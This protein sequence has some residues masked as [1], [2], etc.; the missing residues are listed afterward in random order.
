MNSNQICSNTSTTVT[1]RE[2]SQYFTYKYNDFRE[3]QCLMDVGAKI[4][5][6]SA[7]F[8]GL[9]D[10]NEEGII[11]DFLKDDHRIQIRTTVKKSVPEKELSN[12][13]DMIKE[14]NN[15]FKS[16]LKIKRTDSSPSPMNDSKGNKNKMN[17]NKISENSL[18]LKIKILNSFKIALKIEK[19]QQ[20]KSN[21]ICVAGLKEKFDLVNHGTFKE[22]KYCPIKGKIKPELK[23]K[24]L[25]FK[26]LTT[27]FEERLKKASAPDLN[28]SQPS[29]IYF[30]LF[31]FLQFVSE[32]ANLFT[33]RCK[34]CGK[35]AK[36]NP[37][38]K[39]F[40]PP[41]YRFFDLEK[42]IF[43]HEDCFA[44]INNKAA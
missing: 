1:I 8:K 22:N 34:F 29:T 14:F 37:V 9:F 3:T 43:Y 38:E 10:L 19:D 35:I 2:L 21:K 15:L 30:R 41:Y 40:Y 11:K 18:S 5:F 33:K 24:K 28:Q 39:A 16:K 44:I 6:V 26:K 42:P 27:L 31:V 4:T 13:E 23:S 36:Y 17:D 7:M 32:Y 12:F 20:N 25:L